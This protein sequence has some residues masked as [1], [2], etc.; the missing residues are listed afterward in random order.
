MLRFG[1][2]SQLKFSLE[3]IPELTVGISGFLRK[4]DKDE[5]PKWPKGNKSGTAGFPSLRRWEAF[6]F[7]VKEI[8]N[9]LE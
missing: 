6:N 8:I 4:K 3:L 5:S 9:D 7:F 1:V 2:R